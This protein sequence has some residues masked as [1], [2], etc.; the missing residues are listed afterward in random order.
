MLTHITASAGCEYE[1]YLEASTL[2]GETD[3]P[4]PSKEIWAP[5][6]AFVVFSEK[7]A[8]NTTQKEEMGRQKIMRL[9]RQY[10][11]N[12]PIAKLF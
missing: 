12:D 4:F 10:A 1:S 3:V 9:G 6:T 8:K 5:E 2:K 11:N 7:T